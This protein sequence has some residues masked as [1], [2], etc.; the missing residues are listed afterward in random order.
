VR[1]DGSLFFGAV[2]YVQ[3]TLRRM[4]AAEPRQ[5]HL[6][7]VATG[8][9]F[10]DLAGAE[11]LAREAQTRRSQGGD[12][13]L[14]QVKP[15]VEEALDAGGYLQD[16]GRDH[17]F[18]SRGQAIAQVYQR[19]DPEICRSCTRRIFLECQATAVTEAAE[20]PMVPAPVRLVT[21][22]SR[23]TAS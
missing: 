2:S 9:N 18:A 12:L 1:I 5:R 3:Q 22:H 14:I 16:I 11:F 7:V 19:L 13:W 17:L 10:I 20:A 8:I 21:A 6:A 23:S 4:R 15:Q